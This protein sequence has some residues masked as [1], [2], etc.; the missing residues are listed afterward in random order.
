MESNNGGRRDGGR[1]ESGPPAP[2]LQKTG[3][4]RPYR[5]A[6]GTLKGDESVSDSVTE[7]GR[8]V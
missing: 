2:P 5:T 7:E 6:G 4:A 3:F 1:K 8:M